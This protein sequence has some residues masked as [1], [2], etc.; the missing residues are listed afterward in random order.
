MSDNFSYL[1][2]LNQNQR[3]AATTITG[4][5]CVVAGAG[6]GKT[7]T[8]TT[9]I[10]YMIDKG[11]SPFNILAV[12]FTNKAAREMKER[13]INIVGKKASLVTIKTFHSFSAYLL[14]NVINIKKYDKRLDERFKIIDEDDKKKIV[15]DIIKKNFKEE[16][17]SPRVL[18]DIISHFKTG[19]LKLLKKDDYNIIYQKYSEHLLSNN[20]VD[21]DDLMIILFHILINYPEELK[22]VNNRYTHILVDEF[23]DT[24]K[25]QYDLITLLGVRSNNVF[26]VGDPDQSIYSFRGAIYENMNNFVNDN[27]DNIKVITLY[28]N[29]RSVNNILNVSNNLI[30]HNSSPFTKEL[31]SQFGMGND[32]RYNILST[33]NEEA[34]YVI[35]KIKYY[36]NKGYKK[37]DI[38]ILYRLNS[39]SR[40][41][42]ESLLSENIPYKVYGGIS[43][44]MRREIKDIIA[45][46]ALA[47]NKKDNHSLKRIINVPKRKIGQRSIE[48]LEDLSKENKLSLFEN[49]DNKK[50]PISIRKKFI[51]FKNII[52]NISNK[53]ENLE[54]ITDII[55][56]ILDESGYL[57]MLKDEESFE[58]NERLENIYELKGVFYSQLTNKKEYRDNLTVIE[59]FLNDYTLHTNLDISRNNNGITLATIHQVKGLEF[60]IVFI[61]G[62]EENI[63]PF[64][65][66]I[67]EGLEEE[68]RRIFYVAITRAKE[69]LYLTNS[70]K[71]YRYG[72]V[73]FNNPSPFIRELNLTNKDI[74]IPKIINKKR[75]PENEKSFN[76]GDNIKHDIFGSGKIVMI[77]DGIAT[78]AFSAEYGIKKISLNH[79]ALKK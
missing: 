66:A 41:F 56:I 11:I 32:V 63:I 29:Y 21:F 61:I 54:K 5:V 26:I 13:T 9:R 59:D 27:K 19:L 72:K 71:R 60:K 31:K 44:F 15:S 65:S 73:N 30:K 62:L 48:L 57:K 78:I 35:D 47:V 34:K 77:K 74:I 2:E 8:L 38:A 37:N 4:P 51:E 46:L 39:L 24:S 28:E 76:I 64:S 67:I 52:I 79:P 45:Y 3:K 33:D 68:E 20:L 43:F 75:S 16:D 58:A 69:E 53:I 22:K 14:R 42:E 6:T 1:N 49:L 40:I 12:T 55:D 10:A 70:Q 25:I 36:L 17:Y 50:I 7:K 23:Q 18:C